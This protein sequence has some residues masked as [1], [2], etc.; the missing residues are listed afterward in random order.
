VGSEMCIRDS[1]LPDGK[2]FV[3]GIEKT[4]PWWHVEGRWFSETEDSCVVG[5][6]FARRSGI[7]IGDSIVIETSSDSGHGIRVVGILSTAG[8]EDDAIVVPLLLAQGIS[9]KAGQYRKLYV[10]ALTKPEDDF[11]RRDPKTM[12]AGEFE[13]WSCSPY[14]SSIAYSIKQILPGADVRVVRRVAE[15][16]GQI[17]TR[18][19][20]LL[21]LVTGVALLAAA[22]AVGASSAASV[23][24]RRT[25]I[26][27]MKALGAGS[28]TV[29]FLLAAEQ[30]LLAFVGGGVGYAIGIVLARLVGEKIF[31]AA[32][33]FQRVAFRTTGNQVAIG[34][35]THADLRKHMV[36]AARFRAEPAGAVKAAPAVA[37]VDGLAQFPGLQKIGF[38][39]A[40][41]ADWASIAPGCHLARANRGNLLGQAHVH[42]VARSGAFEQTQ[43]AFGNEAAD[44]PAR[45]PGGYVG[46]AGQPADG[47][48]QLRLAFE[49]A[50]PQQMKIY[51]A[52]DHREA[53]P[54]HRQVYQ[55]F[56]H[57][58]GVEVFVFHV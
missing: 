38:L 17:L 27:L 6:K 50:V 14:V 9:D 48:A 4:N 15:G 39:E 41:R 34:V 36:K 24:E 11:G 5:E 29:G 13:R 49:G 54:R 22:L 7:S 3:T 8:P 21:W 43:S 51:R 55:L 57:V 52:L 58:Y 25:E 46:A 32:V 53:Q 31:G 1:S 28:G 37:A 2:S 19:R 20:M 40:G 30:L 33:F 16:E 42:Q 23:I 47:K 45:D 10:S 56:P 26:G 12:N 35:A 18:V 44:D